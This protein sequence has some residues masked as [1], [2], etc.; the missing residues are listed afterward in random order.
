MTARVRGHDDGPQQAIGTVN[1]QAGSADNSIVRK[2]YHKPVI[3][4]ILDARYRQ[5][6]LL[7][8]TSHDFQV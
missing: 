4:L 1:L 5:V 6:S 7:Q 8:Q 2:R 3:V